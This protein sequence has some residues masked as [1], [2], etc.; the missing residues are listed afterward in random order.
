MSS[1]TFSDVYITFL[2]VLTCFRTPDVVMDNLYVPKIFWAIFKTELRPEEVRVSK[3]H[4][5]DFWR[6]W[7]LSK[8]S[9][10]YFFFFTKNF[11]TTGNRSKNIRHKYFYVATSVCVDPRLKST[12]EWSN[13]IKPQIHKSDLN[14]CKWTL[15]TYFWIYSIIF[16]VN[17]WK[18]KLEIIFYI[19]IYQ[20]WMFNWFINTSYR[21]L[22]YL[23]IYV[24]CYFHIFDFKLVI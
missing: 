7:G 19:K 12:R 10:I 9:Q 13:K 20:F 5:G 2:P 21:L 4:F 11:Q 24:Y 1:N 18:L 14:L 8:S 22:V 6:F 16:G 23:Y 17:Q 15:M 3:G